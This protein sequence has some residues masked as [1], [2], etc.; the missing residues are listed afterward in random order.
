MRGK[1]KKTALTP[2]IIFASVLIICVV[3]LC[4]PVASASVVSEGRSGARA[5]ELFVYG[6]KNFESDYVKITV[7]FKNPPLDEHGNYDENYDGR[8]K[9]ESSLYNPNDYD[10]SVKIYFSEGAAGYGDLSKDRKVYLGDELLTQQKA[11][12]IG[13][14]GSPVSDRYLDAVTGVS[15]PDDA[16]SPDE[17]VYVYEY[18][19][20]FPEVDEIKLFLTGYDGDFPVIAQGADKVN[21]VV[22]GSGTKFYTVTPGDKNL[23]TVASVGRPLDGT[24]WKAANTYGDAYEG[25][26]YDSGITQHSCVEMSYEDYVKDN[27][28]CPEEGKENLYACVTA[29]LNGADFVEEDEIFASRSYTCISIV[30]VTIPAGERRVLTVDEKFFPG[31]MKNYSPPVYVL[32]TAAPFFSYGRSDF[33]IETTIN[34]PFYAI[35]SDRTLK[36][37]GASYTFRSEKYS[38]ATMTVELC[39]SK[40]PESVPSEIQAAFLTLLYLMM[41]SPA[42]AAVVIVVLIVLVVLLAVG[43][44]ALIRW[45]IK[46]AKKSED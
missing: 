26:Y 3:L 36:K 40:E 30:D 28:Y 32:E 41:A 42:V 33:Y 38:T 35:D 21:Y 7:D 25:K 46:T 31:I 2:K 19:L 22:G 6:K 4:F 14:R 12:V 8:V 37:S 11:Y 23:V 44:T 18:Y 43:I 39:A 24:V 9:L 16:I 17:K 34:T 45:L 29:Y 15:D 10:S 1:G 20:S 13:F 27:L 5:G